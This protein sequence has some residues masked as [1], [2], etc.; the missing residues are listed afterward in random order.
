[1]RVNERFLRVLVERHVPHV[2]HIDEGGHD[3]RVSKMNLYQ[4]APRIIRQ[5]E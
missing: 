1:M 3:F 2:W 5:P 4:F